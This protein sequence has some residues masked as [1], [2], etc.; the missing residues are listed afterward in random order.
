MVSSQLFAMNDGEILT[1]HQQTGLMLAAS[2]DDEQVR[3]RQ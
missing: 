3:A 2:V 1:R